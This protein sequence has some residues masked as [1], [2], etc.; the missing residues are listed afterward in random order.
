MASAFS[1]AYFEMRSIL[2]RVLWNLDMEI[3]QESPEWTE[4]KEYALWDKPP[5]WV[6]LKHK[7]AAG[8]KSVRYKHP[9]V[10]WQ[11]SLNS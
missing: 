1:L 7:G 4:Q 6:R 10:L 2:A 5:L 11:H 3:E 9:T 8:G